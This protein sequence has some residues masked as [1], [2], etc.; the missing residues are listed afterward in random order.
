MFFAVPDKAE[1]VASEYIVPSENGLMDV[2]VGASNCVVVP[3]KSRADAGAEGGAGRDGGSFEQPTEARAKRE[4]ART[5]I[6]RI[7]IPRR[8][9]TSGGHWSSVPSLGS[10]SGAAGADPIFAAILSGNR[11]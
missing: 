10:A 5:R 7:F 2:T 11:C 1:A 8:G 3:T 9:Q 6:L 4:Q